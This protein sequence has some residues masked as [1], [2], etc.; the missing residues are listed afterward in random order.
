MAYLLDIL[1]LTNE[2]FEK[3]LTNKIEYAKLY[4]DS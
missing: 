1:Y 2:H 3:R 4:T